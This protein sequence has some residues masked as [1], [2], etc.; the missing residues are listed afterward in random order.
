MPKPPTKPFTGTLDLP[1]GERDGSQSVFTTDSKGQATLDI[2]FEHCLQ[3]T[4]T[5]LASGLA[6]ALHSDGK[7]YGPEPGGFG[8]VTHVQLFAMLPDIDDVTV[9]K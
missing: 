4:D 2:K 7:T 6:V 9:G 8:K 3:L 1:I 5:Q